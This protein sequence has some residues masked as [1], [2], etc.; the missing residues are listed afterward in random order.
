[1]EIKTSEIVRLI[2]VPMVAFLQIKL[3][4]GMTLMGE[5]MENALVVNNVF[6]IKLQKRQETV[7]FFSF[8]FL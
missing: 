5:T 2:S 3:H 1:M 8:F 4:F 6:V 7:L